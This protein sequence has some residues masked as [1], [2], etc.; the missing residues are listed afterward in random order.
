MSKIEVRQAVL[1][2]IETVALLFDEYRQFYGRESDVDAGRQFLLSRFNHGES[3]IFIATYEGES[4]GFTQLYPSFSSL[5]LARAFVLNDLYVKPAARRFGAGKQLLNSAAEY[6]QA[7]GAS[8]L[9]LSTAVT[10]ES[11]QALYEKNGWQR[12]HEF[13]V[14]NLA[15]MA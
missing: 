15:V 8:W 9:T 12:D 6:A 13:L 3:V 5:S 7:L 4:I 14:Y 2:D 11:A 1:S 10:N